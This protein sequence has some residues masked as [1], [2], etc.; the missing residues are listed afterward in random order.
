MRIR[1]VVQYLDAISALT[2]SRDFLPINLRMEVCFLA[3][4]TSTANGN[5]LK[6]G[7]A[8]V[9]RSYFE[10]LGE[11]NKV[12]LR[13]SIVISHKSMKGRIFHPPAYINTT[14][15]TYTQFY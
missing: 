6:S 15:F 2:S 5:N 13:H 3:R 9:L 7:G 8:V 10:D 11:P 4:A 12:A 1:Y 14:N